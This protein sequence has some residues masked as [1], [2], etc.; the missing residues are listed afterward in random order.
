MINQQV[1]ELPFAE[2]LRSLLRRLGTARLE[3]I[4]AELQPFSNQQRPDVVLIPNS[5][6]Y[7]GQIIFIEIKLSTKPI[8]DSRGFQNL[9]EHKDFAAEALEGSIG[10]YVYVTNASV[11]EFSKKFLMERGIHVLDVV[12][13]EAEVVDRLKALA[14]ISET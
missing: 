14:A 2:A 9:I 12:S 11:P 13:T 5:G 3:Y 6:G 1:P 10:R 8:R 7:A 4:T